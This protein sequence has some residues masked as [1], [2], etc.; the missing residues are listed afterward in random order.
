[1]AKSLLNPEFQ[2]KFQSWRDCNDFVTRIS[3]VRGKTC[4]SHPTLHGGNSKTW[5]C[6]SCVVDGAFVKRCKFEVKASKNRANQLIK[7]SNKNSCFEHSSDCV[8]DSIVSKSK[9]NDMKKRKIGVI[10]NNQIITQ[11]KVEQQDLA[12]T[13]GKEYVRN[14]Y[15]AANLQQTLGLF[16]KDKAHILEILS[17]KSELQL[18]FEFQS[19][20]ECN[21]FVTRIS[22]VRG[23]TCRSHPTL[24]G[25]NSKTWICS[26]CV[27]DGAFVKRC[28]FE[29]KASKNRANQLIKISNKNSC[30]EHSSDCESFSPQGTE[31]ILSSES[32][33]KKIIKLIKKEDND[34]KLNKQLIEQNDTEGVDDGNFHED[35]IY[36]KSN[37][38]VRAVNIVLLDQRAGKN[39]NESEGSGNRER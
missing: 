39:D 8:I 9:T 26:S 27:V 24:H 35:T 28:K 2:L 11:T 19:W 22:Q 33:G 38:L 4:R 3:Q 21:D 29:V 31:R 6:S 17:E 13:N 14:K 37:L 32:H 34:K 5:I 18:K 10:K 25:G 20:R 16:E 12:P 36:R 1:M 23:K 7:I 30:F 15:D